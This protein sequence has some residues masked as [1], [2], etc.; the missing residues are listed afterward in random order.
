MKNGRK[1]VLKHGSYEFV[2]ITLWGITRP[3]DINQLLL[4]VDGNA[5]FSEF[6]FHWNSI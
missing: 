2:L 1:V 4:K 6:I 5:D 3:A